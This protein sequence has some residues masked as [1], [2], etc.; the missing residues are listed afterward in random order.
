MTTEVGSDRG[1]RINTRY[2]NIVSL[3]VDRACSA[4]SPSG[5]TMWSSE[6]GH[7]GDAWAHG[8]EEG[9]GKLRKARGSCTRAVIPR[10]P[11]GATHGRASARISPLSGLRR[12]R[13]TET[14][15]YPEEEESIEMPPVAASERGGAQSA[16]RQG[17]G[18]VGPTDAV[19]EASGSPL[20]RGARDGESP[21]GDGD[22]LTVVEFLSSARPEKSGAKPG[23]PPS[24]AKGLPCDR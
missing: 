1:Q 16:P 9:R 11:N 18:V 14:S 5:E 23:G 21:V 19:S 22:G 13:G 20:E 2:S 7:V 8:G 3:V 4:W 24:K 12:T 17:G 6:R 15:Q 10:W